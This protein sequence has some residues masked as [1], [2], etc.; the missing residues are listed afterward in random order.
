MV[1][2]RR[3]GHTRPMNYKTPNCHGYR[4]PTEIIHNA[5]WLYHR[6]FLRFRKIED[7]LAGRDITVSYE[8]IR[9]LILKFAH[10][11]PFNPKS[12]TWAFHAT[13]P[14]SSANGALC[15]IIFYRD[16]KR[17]EQLFPDLCIHSITPHSPLYYWLAGGLRSWSLLPGSLFH[18]V[19]TLEDVMS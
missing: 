16:R 8:T 10:H 18:L 3:A 15:W 12:K 1:T 9:H 2:L 13:G 17:F 14:L 5:I 6:F 19:S 11:E 4:F 7:L